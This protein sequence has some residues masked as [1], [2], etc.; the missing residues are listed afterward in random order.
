L[1]QHSFNPNR[2]AIFSWL[3]VLFALATAPSVAGQGLSPS[4]PT[5]EFIYF[6]G[7]LVAIEERGSGAGGNAVR[8]GGNQPLGSAKTAA[9]SAPTAPS[10]ANPPSLPA[11]SLPVPGLLPKDTSTTAK[12]LAVTTP[13]STHIS[14][15]LGSH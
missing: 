15:P 4:S 9:L 6:N 14:P 5:Q 13:A 12:R 11:P 7:R 3:P 10:S 8:A 2:K 1:L